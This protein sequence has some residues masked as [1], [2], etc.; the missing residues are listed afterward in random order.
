MSAAAEWIVQ[1]GDVAGFE[2]TLFGLFVSDYRSH[3]RRHGT[4]VHRHV[5]AHGN[6]LASGIDTAQE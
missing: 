4:Q 5:I 1:H 6:D 2:F 3:R